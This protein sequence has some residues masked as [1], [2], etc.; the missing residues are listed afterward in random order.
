MHVHCIA[1]SGFGTF[2]WLSF[3][4]ENQCDLEACIVAALP[5]ELLLYE[6]WDWTLTK[7]RWKWSPLQ[8][9]DY[10]S[11]SA[12]SRNP[13]FETLRSFNSVAYLH[14]VVLEDLTWHTC[15]RDTM[16]Y[17]PNVPTARTFIL[18][19]IITDSSN[20]FNMMTCT[21]FSA[22]CFARRSFPPLARNIGRNRGL[23]VS[24]CEIDQSRSGTME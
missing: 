14:H 12:K 20:V 18:G 3:L 17:F 4:W 7:V 23:R 1:W 9:I 2:A 11:G 19:T 8:S 22:R 10:H 21:R 24:E 5:I 16:Y 6:Y 13:P 15:T